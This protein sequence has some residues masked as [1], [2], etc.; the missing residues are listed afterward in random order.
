MS[1]ALR[2]KQLSVMKSQA[3]G[4]ECGRCSVV[5]IENGINRA[6]GRE[7]EKLKAAAENSALRREKVLKIAVVEENRQYAKVL[8][9]NIK[10]FVADKKCA[11]NVTVVADAV[12]FISDYRELY[13]IV[14]LSVELSGTDGITLAR[15][16]RRCDDSVTLF[17]T[18]H[19]TQTA[20]EGY[21]VHAYAYMLKTTDYIWFS[22]RM[23]EA[24]EKIFGRPSDGHVVV[25]GDEI[26]CLSLE[27]IRYIEVMEHT[28]YYHTSTSDLPYSARGALSEIEDKF[29]RNGFYRINKS[30]MVNM[31]Y[32]TAV[33]AGCVFLGETQIAISRRKKKEFMQEFAALLKCKRQMY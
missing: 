32:I 22:K 28:L 30:F 1:P 20:M 25:N 7:G 33:R 21:S 26:F 14:F 10:R 31:R 8:T 2:K 19:D 5:A 3:C 15:R 16:L 17:L 29:Y 11:A 9:D 13:D 12:G 27:N 18:S 4:R 23:D 24:V 6:R